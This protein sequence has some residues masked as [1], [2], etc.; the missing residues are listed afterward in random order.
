MLFRSAFP[1]LL[2]QIEGPG[3]PRWI[4]LDREELALGRAEEAEIRI[5]TNRASRRH[6]VFH[7][8]RPA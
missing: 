1:F 2:R 6:A 5:E 8:E 3:A 7:T 4:K